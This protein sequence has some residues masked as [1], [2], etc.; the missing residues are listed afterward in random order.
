MFEGETLFFKVDV[1]GKEETL[2]SEQ[3]FASFLTHLSSILKH[4]NLD[5]KMIVF[6][7]PSY[8]S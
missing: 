7:I 2:T 8:F 6:S 4:N 1:N 5:T 3:V